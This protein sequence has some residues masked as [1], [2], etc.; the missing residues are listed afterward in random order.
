M[1][2]LNIFEGKKVCE[3][4]LWL[5]RQ[6]G[7]YL[8][9]YQNLRKSHTNFMNLCFNTDAIV[10]ATLQPIRRFNFDAAIIFSDILTIPH[11]LGQKV[12]FEEGVGPILEK[13]DWP[14]FLSQNVDLSKS[15]SQLV[16][17]I[18]KTRK[19][20]SRE[21]ALVGFAGTPWTVLTYMIEGSKSSN[22]K[23]ILGF[24]D[25]DHKTFHQLLELIEN[26]VVELLSLQIEAGCNVVQLFDSWA[27]VAPD[28][29]KKL[30]VIEPTLRIINRIHQKFPQTPIIYYGRR[31]FNIYESFYHLPNVGMSLDESVDIGLAN[32]TIPKHIVVQGNLDPLALLKGDLVGVSK[33]ISA[34][35][36]RPF[37]FNLGHGILPQTPLYHVEKLV[38]LVKGHRL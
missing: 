36:D 10:E 20:L 17:A 26:A 19:I 37:I 28:N 29:Q 24:V 11:V 30:L 31:V 4:V 34:F 18:K 6:A 27:S 15:Y 12:R 2:I 32:K 35:Q 3:Q 33:I 22:F 8:P 38:S 1:Y 5:M 25:D 9:E 21:K 13:V 14:W 16:S 23:N 7:R